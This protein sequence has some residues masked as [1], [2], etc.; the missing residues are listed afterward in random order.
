MTK[1]AAALCF[2]LLSLTV[3]PGMHAEPQAPAAPPAAAGAAKP[4][5]REVVQQKLQLV[6]MLM[7][8]STAIGRASQSDDAAIK[9]QAAEVLAL[10]A[11]AQSTFDAGDTAETEKLLDEV[12]RL[13]TDISRL[14]PD[15]VRVEAERRARYD[16]ILD[17]VRS[18]QITY[19]EIRK[20]MSDKQLPII[21]ANMERNRNLIDQA[22]TLAQ[23]KR[24]PEAIKLLE[25]GY[26]AGVSDLTKLMDSV[27]TTYEAKFNSPAEEFDY[28]MARY[29]SYEE[30][31]PIAHVELKP[32]EGS[33]KMSERFVQESRVA[34]DTAKQ[35][36]AGGDHQAAVITLQGATKRLQTALRTLGLMTPE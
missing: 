35:Q 20:D 15:P 8:Q 21:N 18:I 1:R 4:S 14:A 28:E 3:A 25:N 17:N 13:I 33:V 19:Q 16:E 31:I 30:L 27:I 9:Q 22:Q 7:A 23:D 34:H 24:Y 6:K 26:A 2:T 36:A 10:Y 32:N 11:K 5:S 12:L 29:R